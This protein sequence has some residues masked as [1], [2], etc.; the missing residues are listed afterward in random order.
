MSCISKLIGLKRAP[1]H[2]QSP[3]HPKISIYIYKYSPI[4]NVVGTL[5][6]CVAMNMII[7][8]IQNYFSVRA[9]EAIESTTNDDRNNN[10]NDN[11]Q[12]R[13]KVSCPHAHAIC[14]HVNNGRMQ[15]KQLSSDKCSVIYNSFEA[16]CVVFRCCCWVV[17]A[18]TVD[19][20][21][22]CIWTPIVG[23]RHGNRMLKFAQ[24]IETCTHI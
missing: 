2:A 10:N 19:G 11:G 12:W 13:K 7:K 3:I 18:F 14:T 9:F 15:I 1:I 4:K 5:K 24:F 16:C 21:Y 23:V 17:C 22:T 20:L 8:V 6:S